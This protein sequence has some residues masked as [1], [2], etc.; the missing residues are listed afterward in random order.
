MVA[1]EMPTKC[2]KCG[3]SEV[4][5]EEDV[6]DTWF[7]SGLW[8]FSTL[9]WPE[10]TP[11]LETFYPTDVLI[12][13]FDILFFWVARMVMMGLHLTD[14]V[15]FHTVHLT[16]LVRDAEGRKMSKTKGN[17]VDPMDLVEEYGADALRFTLAVL[18]SPGR[19]IP[20][21]PERMA[22]YR[23]FGN[24]IWNAV[25][26]AL[27]R[28][29]GARVAEEIDLTG[30]AVPER[31]ILSR[32]AATAAEVHLAVELPAEGD[33]DDTSSDFFQRGEPSPAPAQPPATPPASSMRRNF[34]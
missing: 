6:L 23:A 1:K 22:G 12:T 9:G 19:D 28:T 4:T 16:G 5:Q 26:F 17:T 30:L 29:G 18:D 31:W 7:S 32:L 14:E 24:K 11:D 10:E 2:P 25:R 8:P 3:A 27:A 13:G 15:P 20:L 34:A 21:D 33:D